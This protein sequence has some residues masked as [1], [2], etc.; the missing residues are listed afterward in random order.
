[1]FIFLHSIMI[2]IIKKYKKEAAQWQPL[3]TD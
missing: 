1:L 2:A 3:F